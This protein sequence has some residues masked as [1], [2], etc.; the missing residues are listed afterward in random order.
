MNEKIKLVM[1]GFISLNDS[2]RKE[3]IDEIN[4]WIEADS[5]KKSIMNE[6]LEKCAADF[7]RVNTGPYSSSTCICCGR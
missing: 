3:L 4:K 2:E 5:L 7:R 1:N 6:S